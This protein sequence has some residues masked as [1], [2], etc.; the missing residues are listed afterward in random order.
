M[1]KINVTS[2][3]SFRRFLARPGATVTVVRHD[4]LDN[5]RPNSPWAEP[6]KRLEI[7]A[8]RQVAKLQLNA[9]KW[10]NGGWTYFDKTWN[11][12]GAG[13]LRFEGATVTMDLSRTRDFSAVCVYQ[14]SLSPPKISETAAAENIG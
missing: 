6:G 9:V 13:G 7:T 14:L 10:S 4:W 12:R 1:P 11:G 2:L 8:P 3:A 5:A